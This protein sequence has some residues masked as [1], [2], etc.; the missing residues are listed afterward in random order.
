[1]MS[2]SHL[3]KENELMIS[4][5]RFNKLGPDESSPCLKKKVGLMNPALGGL[6][7][8]HGGIER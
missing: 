8:I 7:V 5:L 2:E 4:I 1:M 3:S 6:I